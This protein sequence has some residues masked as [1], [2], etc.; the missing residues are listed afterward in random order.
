M[1]C[2]AGPLVAGMVGGA[3]VALVAVAVVM[4][5]GDLERPARTVTIQEAPI[6]LPGGAGGGKVSAASAIYRRDAAGVVFVNAS[7]LSQEQSTPEYLRGEG[8]GLGTATGSGFEVDDNGTVVTNLHVVD[9]AR[10]IF[11]GLQDGKAVEAQIVGTDRSLDVALLRIRAGRRVTLHPLSLGDSNKVQVGESVL[12][13]GNPF[14]LGRSLTTGIISGLQ[15]R[16][17]APS[18]MVIDNALQTDAPIN[19]GNSGGPLLDD[20]G[21]VIGINSQIETAGERG[22][23]VGIAFAIP[24]DAVKST[25]RGVKKGG[26]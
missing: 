26:A 16:I 10:K 9:G 23:S 7:G 25:I 19:P 5:T 18:G 20:R 3:T 2:R 21:D 22:G 15:R 13:I 11:V 4:V 12:A 24:I 8:G 1:R 14:G 6:V 17:E